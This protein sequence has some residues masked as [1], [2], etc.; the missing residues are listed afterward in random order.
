MQ[1]GLC[2]KYS[3]RQHLITVQL[4]GRFEI[5]YVCP[6]CKA[7]RI[8]ELEFETDSKTRHIYNNALDIIAKG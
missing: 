8:V 2:N 5:M 7:K 6:E 3:P 4:A 1:C